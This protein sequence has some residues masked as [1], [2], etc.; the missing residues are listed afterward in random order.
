MTNKRIILCL[1]VVGTCLTV[2]AQRQEVAAPKWAAKVQRSIVS[3]LAYDENTELLRS[4]TGVYVGTAGEVVASYELLRGAYSARVADMDGRTWDVECVLGADYNYDVVKLRTT[5]GK[6]SPVELSAQAVAEGG[7]VYALPFSKIKLAVC[8]ATTVERSDTVE[9]TYRYYTLATELDAQVTGDILFDAQGKGVGIVQSPLGGKS[10]ALD[11]R[12]GRDLTISAI[13]TKST[14]LALQGI[15]IRTGLPDAQEEALVYLY[16]QSRSAGNDDY[17]A[18]LNEYIDRWPQSAE[19]Y[20]RRTTILLDLLRFDEA[21]RDLQTYLR[22]SDD[23][24]VANANVAQTIYTKLVYQPEATYD[25]WTFDRA[26]G[27]IRQAVALAED[28]L[29][30][31]TNDTLRQRAEL[32]VLEYRLQEA[33]VLMASGG[34]EEALDIYGQINAGPWASATTFYAASLAHEAAGDSLPV[35]IALLDSAINR[36]P[37][38][39]T[40]DGAAYVLRRGRLL[41]DAGQYRLAVLDYNT[42]AEAQRGGLNATF[43]YDRAMLEQNGRMYQQ[44]I[45]DLKQAIKLQPRV[46]L[47]HVE[48]SGLLLRVGEL[49]GSI[50][51]A[52]DA[53]ALDA[54]LADAYRIRGYARLQQDDR[55]AARDDFDQAINLG[56]ETARALLNTYFPQ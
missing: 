50:Q 43:Y 56:D 27:Y 19:G 51:A 47:Y 23:K 13:P 21:D 53:L 4:G 31:A 29:I 49:D 24:M 15:H 35:V 8:P 2:A 6:S 42:F 32:S 48:M 26:L 41:G 17:L 22:L 20:Y 9:G 25:K 18:L 7:K 11:L 36:L 39:L 46:P 10:Y 55:Q 16:F 40:A 37:Q 1:C 14:S 5:N 28:R 52:T 30:A 54:N 3:V 12:Y 44:A 34:E 45:D 33:Q 38:P